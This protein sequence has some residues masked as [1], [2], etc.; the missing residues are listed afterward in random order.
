[1]KR[2]TVELAARGDK[3]VDSEERSSRLRSVTIADPEPA[4]AANERKVKRP[5][6]IAVDKRRVV[7]DTPHDV[8]QNKPELSKNVLGFLDHYLGQVN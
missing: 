2:D 8:T 5:L 6:A 4:L 7:F 1:M 3:R